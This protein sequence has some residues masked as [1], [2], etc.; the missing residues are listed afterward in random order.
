M[1]TKV[2]FKE[3]QI[4]LLEISAANMDPDQV[5]IPG[6]IRRSGWTVP[7]IETAR[8]RQKLEQKKLYQRIAYL[9]R[10]HYLELQKEGEERL[11]KL[12]AKA[13][14]EILRLQFALHM[15]AQKKKK[16]SGNFYIIVFDIPESKRVYR[17][18]FRKLLK[19]HNFRMLQL[20]VWMTRYD[21]R[22]AITQLLRY[23][24]LESYFEIMEIPCNNCSKR[25]QR[26]VR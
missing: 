13:K 1:S 6:Y 11:W 8:K 18:F 10:K 7:Y 9:K 14:Y 23:L 22:P 26:K 3:F 19:Q 2:K 15:I 20:S 16:W 4:L 21:P 17:D 25:V 5:H 24:E 12:T